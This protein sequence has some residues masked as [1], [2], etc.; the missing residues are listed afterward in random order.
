MPQST[1]I[2]CICGWCGGE[3]DPRSNEVKMQL[4]VSR[5]RG[6]RRGVPCNDCIRHIV[7]GLD[8]LLERLKT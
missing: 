3:F 7:L 4:G 2:V 6:G 5:P 8:R 1:I